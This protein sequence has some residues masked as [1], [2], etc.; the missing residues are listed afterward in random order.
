MEISQLCER[1]Q[2]IDFD[3]IFAPGRSIPPTNGVFIVALEK[4]QYN[5]AC[6]ACC[7][8]DSI[9]LRSSSVLEK[10]PKGY[11]SKVSALHLISGHLSQQDMSNL[12]LYSRSFQAYSGRKVYAGAY[13]TIVA[14]AGSD[15]DHGLPGI[16]HPRLN[17]QP[18]VITRRFELFASLSTISDAIKD[19]VLITRGCKQSH[20]H[21]CNLHKR[22]TPTDCLDLGT[23]LEAA[24][25]RRCLYLTEQQ[26][27]FGCRAMSCCEAVVAHRRN[28]VRSADSGLE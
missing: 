24:L 9:A 18:S 6:P 22:R 15:A 17:I 8:F 21:V 3:A 27:S 25:S 20:L 16:S 10:T 11:H 4:L 13:A 19:T 7:L 26:A 28:E 2:L 1:C 5:A 23:Y 14:G 12:Q